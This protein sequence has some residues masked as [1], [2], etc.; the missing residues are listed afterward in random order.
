MCYNI[1]TSRLSSN[2]YGN[3][4]PTLTKLYLLVDPCTCNLVLIT[5]KGV[6]RYALKPAYNLMNDDQLWR[7]NSLL[8]YIKNKCI[9]ANISGLENHRASLAVKS[10]AF[11]GMEFF[12]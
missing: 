11:F 8:S 2:D 3:V 1:I 6:V 12:F 9:T 7:Q 10:E 4:S 5:S